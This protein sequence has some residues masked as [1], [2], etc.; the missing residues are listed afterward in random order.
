MNTHTQTQIVFT[1]SRNEPYR[2]SHVVA[3]R[4]G[5]QP[6]S[7]RIVMD[8]GEVL[9][10]HYADAQAAAH[11]LEKLK[12]GMC[13]IVDAGPDDLPFWATA[14]NAVIVSQ[15]VLDAGGTRERAAQAYARTLTGVGEPAGA[16]DTAH[17]LGRWEEEEG[18][19]GPVLVLAGMT[20]PNHSKTGSPLTQRS[21]L[22]RLAL[23]AVDS[24]TD[25]SRLVFSVPHED[26][27]VLSTDDVATSPV[28]HSGNVYTW[29]ETHL[30][31]AGVTAPRKSFHWC[32]LN[33]AFFFD[34]VGLGGPIV[35][36]PSTEPVAVHYSV[37]NVWHVR[38]MT[39]L[40]AHFDTQGWS[41]V[42]E[43]LRNEL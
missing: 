16:I 19:D 34:W 27:P 38:A 35:R 18:K 7:L 6:A 40:A 29:G 3:A 36:V 4:F 33:D 30:D 23:L 2:P 9:Q 24:G 11:A 37:D 25:P 1:T 12:H 32:A 17:M 22:A 10:D 13:G 21:P 31:L 28:F 20:E 42:A 26:R 43:Q 5:K 41:A 8:T 15:A 14:E 39:K